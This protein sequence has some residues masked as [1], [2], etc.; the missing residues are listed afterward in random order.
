MAKFL[1]VKENDERLID[2]SRWDFYK[3]QGYRKV[4][5]KK[6]DTN[7]TEPTKAELLAEATA[8]GIDLPSKPTVAVLK[9][10]IAAKK[11]DTGNQQ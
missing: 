3:S 1:I 10:L 4:E 7:E 8:L 2:E 11:A 6:A 5:A 9:E